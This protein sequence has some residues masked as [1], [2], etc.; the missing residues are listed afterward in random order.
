[1]A[2]E[3]I[4]MSTVASGAVAKAVEGIGIKLSSQIGRFA[5]PIVD[6]AVV[7]LGIG[8]RAYLEAS[9]N[10]CRYFKTILNQAQPL[11]VLPYYVHN[12]LYCGNKHITDDELIIKIDRYKHVVI[13]GLAG[14]GKSMFMK[15]LT[16]CKFES[17]GS[18]VPLF[19]ELRQMNSLTQKDLLEFIRAQC[20]AG[21]HNVTSD[22]FSLALVAGAFCLILDG[23]D[24]LNYE[25]RD[26]ITAQIMSI[27]KKY[28][29]VP[30]VVSSRHD[31]RFGGWV[32]FHVFNVDSMTKSQ[33]LELINKLEYDNGVKRRFH[34]EV[35][36]RLYESHTSFLSSPLLTTIMLLTF[37]EFAEIPVKMHAFYSQAF[38]TLFQKHDASKE[39]YQ[40]KTL[41]GMGRDNFKATFA[42]FCA[43]SYLNEK[44]SFEEGELNET[45]ESAVKY[46]KQLRSD[47]PKS[48]DS[49][50]LIADLKEAVCLLQQDG[51]ETAFVHRSFQEY[52]AAL[53]STSLHG[54]KLKKVLDKYALRFGDSVISMAFDMARESIEQEWVIPTT[55]SLEALFFDNDKASTTTSKLYLIFDR[56]NMHKAHDMLYPSFTHINMEILGPIEAL[57]ALYP[58]EIGR[59]H[60]I[61]NLRVDVEDLPDIANP[62]NSNMANYDIFVDA[63]NR[64]NN[65]LGIVGTI[66]FSEDNDWWLNAVGVD[67][68][69]VKLR[70]GFEAIRKDIA[71]RA[72]KRKVILDDFL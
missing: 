67:R 23:F 9:Y 27:V 68:G 66:E 17:V 54:E 34:R 59:G 1:M 70:K 45:A 32:P 28:P 69:F 55:K 58:S 57:A 35:K 38:D 8:F 11:E 71:L 13:T 40:R 36:E 53:F 56:V 24:E 14:S 63:M 30:I 49:N 31:D 42:A 20:I 7:D 51:L 41:T 4:S 19:I 6:R 2:I 29:D 12:K 3:P 61:T 15:Y 72:K 26:D 43:M 16:I 65:H 18:T 5:K 50:N 37:E 52:F 21:G 60:V 39:Q 62:N 22:Q 64:G 10:R 47:V 48:V 46:I 44:F 33:T 25:F